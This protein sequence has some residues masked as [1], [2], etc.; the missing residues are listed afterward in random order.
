[1]REEWRLFRFCGGSLGRSLVRSLGREGTQ[2][3]GVYLRLN[4]GNNTM[5]TRCV[6][7]VRAFHLN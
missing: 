2:T 4:S 1:M 7:A 5:K 3:L 6:G